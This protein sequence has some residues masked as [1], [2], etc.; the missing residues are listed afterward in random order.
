MI[1]PKRITKK[2][3]PEG[4]AVDQQTKNKQWWH[5]GLEPL[6]EEQWEALCDGCGL[7]CLHKLQDDETD[8]FYYTSLSCNLLNTKT[9]ECTDYANRF[10]KVPECLKLTKE[11]YNEALPWLPNSCSYK[12]V[13]NGQDLPRWHHL[14]AGNKAL[15]HKHGMSVTDRVQHAQGIAEEDYQEYV[16]QWVDGEN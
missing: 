2:K 16:L 3:P 7:C 11:N 10:A 15:M 5:D 1:K 4:K 13:A 6:N 12:R 8:E 14:R 9:C